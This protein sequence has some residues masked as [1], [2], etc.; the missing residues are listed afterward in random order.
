[1][2][3]EN[4]RIEGIRERF[5]LGRSWKEANRRSSETSKEILL[6]NQKKIKANYSNL[7]IKKGRQDE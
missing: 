3:K 4:I 7:E 2:D 1:M 5:K 6:S